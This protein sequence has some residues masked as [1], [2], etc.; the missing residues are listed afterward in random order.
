MTCCD[1]SD[2]AEQTSNEAE[3]LQVTEYLINEIS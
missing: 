2:S 3:H 1:K